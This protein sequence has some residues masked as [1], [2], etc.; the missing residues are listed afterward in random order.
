MIWHLICKLKIKFPLNAVSLLF[1]P[2]A[3]IVGGIDG[4]L[5][6]FLYRYLDRFSWSKKRILRLIVSIFCSNIVGDFI[7]FSGVFFIVRILPDVTTKMALFFALSSTLIRKLFMVLI[8]SPILLIMLK[9]Y[10]NIV[11]RKK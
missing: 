5:I 11:D 4:F 9:V 2:V 1:S 3:G 7:M 10:D 6:G 8:N